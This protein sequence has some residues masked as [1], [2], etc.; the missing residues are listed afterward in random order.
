MKAGQNSDLFEPE[1]FDGWE[2]VMRC[3]VVAPF[4]VTK[5][6]I[7]LLTKGAASREN[8]SSSIINISSIAATNLSAV[9]IS[10]VC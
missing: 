7:P 6:F 5:A 4:F 1:S 2:D 10:T 8:G 9:D 3:N